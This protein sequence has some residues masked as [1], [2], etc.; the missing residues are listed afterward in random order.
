ERLAFAAR[1]PQALQNTRMPVFYV[2]VG[3]PDKE[4]RD[5]LSFGVARV[6]LGDADWHW[7]DL[8]RSDRT[9]ELAAPRAA[10]VER[11]DEIARAGVGADVPPQVERD[12]IARIDEQLER[13]PNPEVVLYVHGYR[14]TFD[15]VATTIGSFGHYPGH[16]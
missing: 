14:A 8:L 11:L 13:T 5:A 3:A 7:P 10:A 2:A 15:D 16:G 6:R 12:F 9:S 4:S 1:V